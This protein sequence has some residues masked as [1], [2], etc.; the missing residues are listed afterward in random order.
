MVSGVNRVLEAHRD[1]RRDGE[2]DGERL[3]PD[4]LGCR[5]LPDADA[6]EPVA[7]DAAHHQRHER[8]TRLRH[9]REEEGCV[10]RNVKRFRG[11]L[12]FKAHSPRRAR[13]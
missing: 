9:C 5:R 10:S 3:G 7:E 13:I 6:D 1:E 2:P 12:V 11:G 4:V 8:H